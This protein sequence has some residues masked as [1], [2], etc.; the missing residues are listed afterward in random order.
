[1]GIE[2]VNNMSSDIDV[3]FTFDVMHKTKPAKGKKAN[4]NNSNN[5]ESNSGSTSPQRGNAKKKSTKKIYFGGSLDAEFLKEMK[6]TSSLACSNMVLFDANEQIKKYDNVEEILMDFY[7]TRLRM[8]GSRKKAMLKAMEHTLKKLTNQARFIMMIVDG[9][10]KISKRKRMDVVRNLK[11]E[12]F[13]IWSASKD[14]SNTLRNRAK[15]TDAFEKDEEE[16]GDDRKDAMEIDDGDE[17][18]ELKRYSRGYQY[19]LS[20][21]LSSLI[22]EK[23]RELMKKQDDMLAE[24]NA[25]KQKT[26]KDLWRDDLD[27]L[28]NHLEEYERS[29]EEN[30]K[31][32]R[33]EAQ[34]KRKLMASKLANGKKTTKRKTTKKKKSASTSRE[35]SI[36]TGMAKLFKK[37]ATNKATTNSKKKKKKLLS[38]SNELPSDPFSIAKTTATKKRSKFVDS[39]SDDSESPNAGLSLFERAKLKRNSPQKASA[40]LRKRKRGS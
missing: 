34:K 23:V 27:Q 15:A 12:N 40:N 17:D 19:L 10:L 35:S 13:D 1:M 31:L 2:N 39:D 30:V 28:E 36:N 18:R 9:K 38:T 8:Y 7:E 16:D 5:A 21:S 24:V 14:S 20:M 4:S 6:L 32:Q 22:M 33:Q 37:K 3:A 26:V 25:L 29:Y 11:D